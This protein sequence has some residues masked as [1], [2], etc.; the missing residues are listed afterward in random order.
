MNLK[1][2]TSLPDMQQIGT[3][4]TPIE[5]VLEGGNVLELLPETH[6]ML[7]TP[8]EKWDF[9]NKSTD[10]AKQLYLDLART[11]RENGGI[12]LSA[13]QVGLP[14][15]VFVLDS[16]YGF[17][18][19]IF[20]PIIVNTS[21]KEI[22]MEEGCLSF[23]AMLLKV[24]RPYKVRIRFAEWTG[25]IVTKEF[26]GLTA[27]CIQHEIDHLDGITMLDRAKPFHIELAKRKRQHFRKMLKQHKE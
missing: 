2:T 18:M 16:P 26:E 24:K 4:Q 5:A 22:L 27:R 10:E 15:R 23:P 9:V 6:E 7:R 8:T 13:N 17:P 3:T 14:H 1:N 11:M 25:E 12:G 19:G 20:N 21:E